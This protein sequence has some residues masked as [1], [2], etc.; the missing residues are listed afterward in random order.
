MAALTASSVT[1]HDTWKE[2]G[3]SGRKF[4]AKDV[5]LVLAGHGDEGANTIPASIFGM[6][7]IHSV[8]DVRDADGNKFEMAPSFTGA[9]LNAHAHADGAISAIT[10]TVRLTVIGTD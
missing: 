6:R 1:V 3:T 10:D 4:L 8:R 7:K 5:T 9:T 2:G